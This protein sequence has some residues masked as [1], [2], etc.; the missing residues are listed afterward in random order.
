MIVPLH[1][2]RLSQIKMQMNLEYILIFLNDK[3]SFKKI[4]NSLILKIKF[5]FYLEI[6]HY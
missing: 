6:N 4:N 5:E 3:T 2:L 1:Y